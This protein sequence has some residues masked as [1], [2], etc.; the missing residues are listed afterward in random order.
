MRSKSNKIK[1]Q[2]LWRSKMGLQFHHK[3]LGHHKSFGNLQSMIHNTGRL[4]GRQKIMSY[5]RRGSPI[6]RHIHQRKNHPDKVSFHM[7]TTSDIQFHFGRKL[8]GKL[9]LQDTF[10]GF[11]RNI[12]LDRHFGRKSGEQE[13]IHLSILLQFTRTIGE[14]TRTARTARTARRYWIWY[15]VIGIWEWCVW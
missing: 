3:V 2:V 13:L 6:R 5:T 8:K 10:P 14:R 4:L 7:G 9:L 12:L 15:N 1:M 11:Q